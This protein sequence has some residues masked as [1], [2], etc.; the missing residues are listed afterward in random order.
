MSPAALTTTA[1]A[2]TTYGNYV[3]S[4]GLRQIAIWRCVG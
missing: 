3:V 4:G 2:C 1:S